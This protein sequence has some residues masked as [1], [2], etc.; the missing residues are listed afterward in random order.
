MENKFA[1]RQ[2]CDVDIRF[3]KTKKPFMYFDTANTTTTGMSS[4]SSYAMAKGSRR[5]AFNNP[6]EAT[7]TIEAQVYPFRLFAMMSDGTIDTSAA[8]GVHKTV[9]CTTAGQLT[10]TANAAET[11]QAGTVFV[12]PEGSYGIEASM[13]AGTFANNTFTAT[14]AG[15]LI[16]GEAYEVG[17]I[18][19][20]TGVQKVSFNNN[21]LPEDYYITMNTLDKNEE[22]IYTPFVITAYKASVDR[23]FEMS[24]NSEGDPVSI[25][26]SFS[27]LEDAN[28]NIIDMIEIA[29]SDMY[30]STAA[31]SVVKGGAGPDIKVYNAIGA[32]TA[33]VK[34]SSDSAYTKL[35]AQ[36]S[37]DNDAVIIYADSD[38][39]V[40]SY[41]VTL[42]DTE[43]KTCVIAVAIT[44]S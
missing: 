20:R 5:V 28:G 3:L 40:G 30:T 21:K 19:T 18:A 17:Y 4:E 23:N 1:N 2:V 14:N 42:T 33:T 41:T 6:L 34:D 8:I 10:L 13:I 35:H 37:G 22:G 44:A 36:I 9:S 29:D 26:L 31:I 11:I 25:S 32:V 24:F 12:F 16:V 15:N 27:L 39:A 7:L 43:S 38:A